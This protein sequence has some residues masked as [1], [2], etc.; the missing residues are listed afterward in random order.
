M[1]STISDFKTK[2]GLPVPG[3]GSE[4][5]ARLHQE[6]R[7]TLHMSDAAITEAAS[8]SMAMVVRFALGLSASGGK[9]C[10]IAK[11]SLAGWV[12]LATIRHLVN[13]GVEA[14]V[15]VVPE[16]T[17]LSL[18]AGRQIDALRALGVALPDA[19]SGDAMDEFTAFL[20]QAHNILMGA[21]VPGNSPE[22][23]LLGICDVLNEDRIPVHCVE[24]PPGLDADSGIALPKA[25]YASST[26]SLGAPL[27]G[28]NPGKEYVGRHYVCDISFSQA[29]YA[30]VGADLRQLFSEQ[31]VVQIYPRSEEGA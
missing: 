31:P 3:I 1:S 13:A 4:Q 16:E 29:L 2:A 22:E 12:A 25:L 7:T 6:L 17:G 10:A 18:E 23:F 28:L 14:Q 24:C 11:D 20:G 8:Y 30:S 9:V 27:R 21:Y 26:L 15:L 19:G 5:A